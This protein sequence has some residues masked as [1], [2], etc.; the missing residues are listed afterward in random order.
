MSKE[1][2]LEVILGKKIY[3]GI[4]SKCRGWITVNIKNDECF[5]SIKFDDMEYSENF[6]D[7][8]DAILRGFFTA[9]KV[10]DAF[11]YRWN[12]Y[13]SQELKKKLFYE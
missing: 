5:I 9:D 10:V 4:R 7:L 8:S 13:A 6:Y 12:N 2:R 3:E 11:C 1:D